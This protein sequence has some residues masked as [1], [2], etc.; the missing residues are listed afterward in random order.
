MLL[1]CCYYTVTLFV[2]V[3]EHYNSAQQSCW[4]QCM[5]VLNHLQMPVLWFILLQHHNN[6]HLN[7]WICPMILVLRFVLYKYSEPHPFKINQYVQCAYSYSV[8]SFFSFKSACFFLKQSKKKSK[9][10]PLVPPRCILCVR[11]HILSLF[12]S[13]TK[14]KPPTRT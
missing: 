9:R 14:C 2:R 4:L 12:F 3:A 8:N 11:F 7:C 5:K 1:L 6:L 10:F 13:E